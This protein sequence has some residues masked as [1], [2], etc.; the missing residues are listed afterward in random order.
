MVAS[1]RSLMSLGIKTHTVPIIAII[2]QTTI[3]AQFITL[4]LLGISLPKILRWNASGK[5][6]HMLNA[7]AEPIN[8]MTVSNEGTR[9]ARITM[10][11]MVKTRMKAL[12]KPRV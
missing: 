3:K 5:M 12:M 2:E 4:S 9:I 6:M 7:I 11:A 1:I 10:R 8:A